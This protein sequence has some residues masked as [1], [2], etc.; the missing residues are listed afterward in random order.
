MILERD[1]ELAT[2]NAL[3][4]ELESSGGKV[5]LIR[6]E[7]G[8]GKSA[9]VAEFARQQMDRAHVLRGGSDDLLTPQPLGAFWDIA[10]DAGS[11]DTP[12]RAGDRR[13]VMGAV[14]DLLSRNLRP[15][16]IVLEDTHWADE[17]TLDAVKFLGRRI[18]RTGRRPLQNPRQTLDRSRRHQVR[19]K[20]MSR[21]LRTVVRGRRRLLCRGGRF[22]E[23]VT[24][25]ARRAFYALLTD[26]G[27]VGRVFSLSAGWV[28]N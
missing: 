1:E 6:G 7:A 21:E 15:T 12:L 18:A 14:L 11:V 17:A 8:I 27:S 28:P 19:S 24:L 13:G 25:R 2:L 10:G 20:P 5:V 26:A 9:L 3:V 23:S 22:A 16:I 4:D